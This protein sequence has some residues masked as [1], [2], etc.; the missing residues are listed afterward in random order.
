MEVTLT[1]TYRK[2]QNIVQ[3]M[4]YNDLLRC[5]DLM[6]KVHNRNDAMRLWSIIYNRINGHIFDSFSELNHAVLESIEDFTERS[7]RSTETMKKLTDLNI[8]F[9]ANSIKL[10]TFLKC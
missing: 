8:E 4:T 7:K 1:Y 5:Y 9:L 6:I 10:S 3:T 2:A